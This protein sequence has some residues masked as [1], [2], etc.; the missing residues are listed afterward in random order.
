LVWVD[1]DGEF[2]I[3]NMVVGRIKEIHLRRD[4]RISVCVVDRTDTNR[5]LGV[6]SPSHL[7]RHEWCAALRQERRE[8]SGGQCRTALRGI[9]A[10]AVVRPQ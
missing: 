5:Y 9:E 10:A 6:E 7:Q 8:A 3:I 2:V 4:D 1:W